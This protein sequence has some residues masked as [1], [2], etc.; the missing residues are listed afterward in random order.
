MPKL[1][2]QRIQT[3]SDYAQM[4]LDRLNEL[5]QRADKQRDIGILKLYHF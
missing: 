5:K 3:I 4:F 1:N 2:D